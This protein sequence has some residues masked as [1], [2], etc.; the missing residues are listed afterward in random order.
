[1]RIRLSRILLVDMLA[2]PSMVTTLGMLGRT[3]C[4]L[5]MELLK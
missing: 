1:M 2:F 4:L 3:L 5:Q